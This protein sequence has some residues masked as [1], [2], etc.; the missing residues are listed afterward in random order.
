MH[1]GTRLLTIVCSVSAVFFYCYF[2][3]NVVTSFTTADHDVHDL[4]KALRR[5]LKGTQDTRLASHP[6]PSSA[7]QLVPVARANLSAFSFFFFFFFFAF[8]RE[9]GTFLLIAL[10]CALLR[11]CLLQ[12]LFVLRARTASCGGRAIHSTNSV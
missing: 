9:G 4:K 2:W 3:Q 1:G 5:K 11:S 6:F 7:R 12:G 10:C 8:G